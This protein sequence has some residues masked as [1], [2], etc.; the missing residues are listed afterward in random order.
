MVREGIMQQQ[1]RQ[2]VAIG[3]AFWL[4]AACSTPPATHADDDGLVAEDAAPDLG[5]GGTDAGDGA[6]DDLAQV[7]AVA[8]ALPDVADVPDALAGTDAEVAGTD[9]IAGTDAV[10]EDVPQ[11]DDAGCPIVKPFD[12]TCKIGAK[13]DCANAN[14]VCLFGL[15]TAVQ[16]DPKRW[17]NCGDGT[18]AKCEQ[19][20]P[21]DCATPP[22]L[23]GAKDFT[24]EKTI[25]IWVHG[26]SNQGAD[27]LKGLTYGV[28]TGCDDVL[29]HTQQF[30]NPRVC[31]NLP[32]NDLDPNQM[33]SMEYY[34]ANPAP[35]M[36]KQDIADVEKYPYSGGPT[37]LQRYATILGKFVK[38]RMQVTGATH[39]NMACH[40]MGCLITRQMFENDYEGL[41]SSQAIVRWVTATG[42]VDGAQLAW[43]FDSP[44][45]QQAAAGIGLELSDFILMNPDYV[46]DNTPWWDHKLYSANNPLFKG[47]LIHHIG[48][49][50]N[51]VKQAFNIT[52]LDLMF[53]KKSDPNDGIM[54]TQDEY[55]HDQDT[56]VAAK[57]LA[58]DAV[59]PTRTFVYADHMNCPGT[60]NTAVNATAALFHHRKVVITVDK[61][62]LLKDRES[63]APF[64]GEVGS[65][66][67][68]IV[69]ESEARF[70]PYLKTAFPKVT[71]DLMVNND[72]V[73][74]RTAPEWQQN[75]K[76]T[77]NPNVVVFSGPVFD[78]MTDMNLHVWINEADIYPHYAV[79]E[80]IPFLNPPTSPLVEFNGQVPLVDGSTFTASSQYGN[81]TFKVRVYT[82][83]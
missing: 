8:D 64:D 83:Y 27:K 53:P 26:F 78:A 59:K 80:G 3:A 15:C 42:V 51:R 24:G 60:L 32:G 17:D 21:V 56:A 76:D 66:P 50:D 6:A 77:T 61:F 13:D 30:G 40:S 34:G 70:T 19:N 23:T 71:E 43:W 63:H 81:A 55:F 33:V 16:L 9:A 5:T 79:A 75:E 44:T 39:V 74:Y 45:V 72:K 38:W 12:Y 65:P 68:E 14:G 20:C 18:C 48:A 69:V 10:A 82:M 11:L 36:S 73:E 2:K 25:T 46:W 47:L 29:E 31:G 41:A 54:Y 37:G 67:A 62:E 4:V 57:S 35:W 22:T 1:L 49:S 52:L 58:G 7:D 28:V